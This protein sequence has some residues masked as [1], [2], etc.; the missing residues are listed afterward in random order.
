[1]GPAGVRGGRG[2]CRPGETAVPRTHVSVPVVSL[3]SHTHAGLPAHGPHWPPRTGRPTLP[4]CAAS[5]RSPGRGDPTGRRLSPLRLSPLPEL[6]A[7]SPAGP[8]ADHRPG[9]SPSTP[10]ALLAAPARWA[11]R[12]ESRTQTIGLHRPILCLGGWVPW[13]SPVRRGRARSLAR[14]GVRGAGRRQPR[15]GMCTP[16]SDS[17]TAGSR[18]VWEGEALGNTPHPTALRSTENWRRAEL[19]RPRELR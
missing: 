6:T 3:L 10:P 14:C 19:G 18:T 4:T 8:T 13:V 15:W 16:R 7:H 2:R 9:D 1:M 11:T 5:A 12:T 17:W